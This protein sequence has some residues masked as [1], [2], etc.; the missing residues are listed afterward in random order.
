[1]LPQPLPITAAANRLLKGGRG[2]KGQSGGPKLLKGSRLCLKLLEFDL[3]TVAWPS[4]A[5]LPACSYCSRFCK[6]LRSS[7]RRRCLRRRR[8]H[9][10]LD[11]FYCHCRRLCQSPSLLISSLLSS[12]CTTHLNSG[13]LPPPPGSSISLSLPLS[14]AASVPQGR[15]PLAPSLPFSS[16]LFST[17]LFAHL[18]CLSLSFIPPS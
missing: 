10:Q 15:R 5:Q 7:R 6:G 4:S 3:P 11:L 2:G 14:P 1:M 13:A 18:P 16:L 8:R 12:V 17:R 9:H